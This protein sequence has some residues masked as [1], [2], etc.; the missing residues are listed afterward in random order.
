MWVSHNEKPIFLSLF[1]S[2]SLLLHL[3]F[4]TFELRKFFRL[5]SNI[6]LLFDKLRDRKIFRYII[7]LSSSVILIYILFQ[8]DIAIAQIDNI[9]LTQ[10][11]VLLLSIIL[12]LV[13]VN[14]FLEACRGKLLLSKLQ[15]VTIKEAFL[16]VLMG[17]ATGVVS[18]VRIG[19]FLGRNNI[20]E[21]KNRKKATLVRGIGSFIFTLVILIGA[22]PASFIYL[23]THTS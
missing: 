1:Y 11:G 7:S 4:G 22:L 21:I 5:M 17:L 9:E 10:G 20:C 12:F 14:W 23:T 3:F 8:K 15:G 13:F 16:S 19:E 6:V 2:L 18:P